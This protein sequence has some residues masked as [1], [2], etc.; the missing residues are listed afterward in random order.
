V[1]NISFWRPVAG[2]LESDL[3][4][5][6]DTDL[7]VQESNL[8]GFVQGGECNRGSYNGVSMAM[9]MNLVIIDSSL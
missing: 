2:V 6:C 3:K 4:L 8:L 9:F 7:S 5:N 1:V